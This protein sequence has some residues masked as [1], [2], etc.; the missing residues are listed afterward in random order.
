MPADPETGPW[1]AA[2]A[3][4]FPVNLFPHQYGHRMYDPLI[5]LQPGPQHAY[6]T[7]AL[8][9]FTPGSHPVLDAAEDFSLYCAFS[10][11]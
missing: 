7:T 10:L 9:G 8:P 5:V 3:C 4:A 11:A 6:L 2:L 1:T